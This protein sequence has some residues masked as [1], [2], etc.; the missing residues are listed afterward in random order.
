MV[1]IWWPSSFGVY[2]I[3]VDMYCGLGDGEKGYAK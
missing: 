2:W 1:F 3:T